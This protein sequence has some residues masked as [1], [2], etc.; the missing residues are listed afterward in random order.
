M[1]VFLSSLHSVLALLYEGATPDSETRTELKNFMGGITNSR[2]LR[3]SYRKITSAFAKEQQVVFKNDIYVSLN[4]T[5]NVTYAQTMNDFYNTG[6]AYFNKSDE[7]LAVEK[8][9]N[10]ISENTK[11]F[12][13][14]ALDSV[15][16]S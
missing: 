6:Y 13:P 10:I 11:G 2:L 3:N 14:K 12:I 9:N 7:N 8:I 4:K 16:D 1:Y 15:R 5:A